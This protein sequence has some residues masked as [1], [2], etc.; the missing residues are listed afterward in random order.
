[1]TFFN[2][3]GSEGPQASPWIWVYVVVTVLL[4]A[5][6]QVTWAIMSKKKER[7]IGQKLLDN[8]GEGDMGIIT[9]A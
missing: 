4:T 6:I 9:A 3:L 2:F 5:L 8:R 7:I 1:M